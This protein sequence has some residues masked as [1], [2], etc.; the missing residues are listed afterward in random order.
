M[1][2]RFAAALLLLSAPAVAQGLWTIDGA[3]NAAQHS[4]PPLLPCGMPLGPLLAFWSYANPGPCATPGPL[5]AGPLGDVGMDR[6]DDL[7]WITDGTIAAGYQTFSTPITTGIDVASLLGAPVT[8]LD[9]DRP[10]AAC[11]SPTGTARPRPRSPSPAP[12]TSRPRSPRSPCRSRTT[13]T[14][15][16]AR[17]GHQRAVGRRRRRLPDAGDEDRSARPLRLEVGGEPRL[18]PAPRAHRRGGRP[19]RPGGPRVRHRRRHHRGD[20]RR[21]ARRRPRGGQVLLALQLLSLAG[22]GGPRPGGS[23]HGQLLR[24]ALAAASCR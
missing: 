21:C 12:A 14:R 1:Q 22:G 16:L 7:L 8:G 4:G 11:G 9:W 24:L 3:G 20:Q 6:T 5:G 17:P 23:G 19:G 18:P 10:S 2:S 13:A 15:A